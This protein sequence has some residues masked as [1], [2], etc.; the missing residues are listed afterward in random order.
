MIASWDWVHHGS[1]WF[2]MV[3]HATVLLGN[4]PANRCVLD[5]LRGWIQ[6]VA[7][8]AR[9]RHVTNDWAAKSL[10]LTEPLELPIW[11]ITHPIDPDHS[12]GTSSGHPGWW[13][14]W[15]ASDCFPTQP[16]WRW[17]ITHDSCDSYAW[18]GASGTRL[19]RYIEI[20]NTII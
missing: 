15:S 12:C 16:H 19:P 3:H 2:T 9:I 8:A 13:H 18:T 6:Q 11:A 5:M 4:L 1:P 7:L 14:Q 10:N 17:R 20:L